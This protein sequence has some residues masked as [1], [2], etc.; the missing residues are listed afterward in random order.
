M[1][2]LAL[3]D[4]H[5][6]VS[7]LK[8]LIKKVITSEIDIIVIAGDLTQFET[9]LNYL[10]A[11]LN[12]M[13]KPVLIIPGNHEDDEHLT[14]TAKAYPNLIC[15]NKKAVEFQGYL[16]L[17][18][19]GGGFSL[20]DSQFKWLARQWYSE[21][22]NQKIIL[23]LHGPP[24]GTSLDKIDNRHV[25]NKDFRSFIERIKPKLVIC[26]HL[27][28]NAGKLDTIGEI[29]LINPGWEGMIVEMG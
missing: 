17:G 18:Y 27:H 16:F 6:D 20:E 19:G 5:G 1:K 11:K 2:I 25:G 7:I 12:S 15:F 10:L 4:L 21:Y 9:N 26:G 29:K 28:E 24:F 8:S 22:Q 3:T 14:E 13:N 23:V